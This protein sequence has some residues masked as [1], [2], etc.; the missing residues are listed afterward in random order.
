[1]QPIKVLTNIKD[2][3]YYDF[4]EPILI[5]GGCKHLRAYKKWNLDYLK[6]KFNNVE[7]P[8]EKY[9][10]KEHINQTKACPVPMKFNDYISNIKSEDPYYYCAELE[11]EKYNTSISR[12][13]YYD[14]EDETIYHRDNHSN[15]I[16]F[17][18]NKRSGCHLH[19]NYDFMLNQIMGKKEVYLFNFKDNPH[20]KMRSFFQKRNNFL[21]DDFFSLDWTKLNYQKICLDEGDSL[22]IPPFW[23]HATNG[24]DINCSITKVFERKF[25]EYFYTYPYLYFL[26][27]YNVFCEYVSYFED[28]I[29]L[30]V[31]KILILLVII[32]ILI[33][34]INN[35]DLQNQVHDLFKYLN[36]SISKTT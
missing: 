31:I 36:K 21:N 15:L 27:Q 26:K 11:L 34:Y 32:L 28:L 6:E 12:D 9:E 35:K 7:L 33:Y 13:I 18:H 4:N 19:V 2:L 16:F 10:K 5:K 29:P 1:M 17:G 22:C 30:H 3:D 25:D 20:L 23:F 8:I 14:I 24:I